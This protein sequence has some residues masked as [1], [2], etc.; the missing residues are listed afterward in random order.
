VVTLPRE[1]L[2]DNY[3]IDKTKLNTAGGIAAMA[4]LYMRTISHRDSQEF[5]KFVWPKLSSMTVH[6]A[7]TEILKSRSTRVEKMLRT[8]LQ[9]FS[10]GSTD[11]VDNTIKNTQKFTNAS[12]TSD[13][14]VN[15]LLYA[16]NISVADIAT[17]GAN[18]NLFLR[19]HVSELLSEIV[20][21]EK[22]RKRDRKRRSSAT[23]K[24]VINKK[25]ANYVEPYTELPSAEFDSKTSAA[26]NPYTPLLEITSIANTKQSLALKD[27]LV[28]D[29]AKTGR[30]FIMIENEIFVVFD[31][32]PEKQHIELLTVK[33]LGVYAGTDQHAKEVV[34]SIRRMCQG[35]RSDTRDVLGG[36]ERVAAGLSKLAGAR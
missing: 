8:T 28:A 12:K 30:L 7:I 3:T 25:H 31:N 10:T 20:I 33:A 16:L 4:A 9:L 36:A 32:I 11:I 2:S 23:P 24:L 27:K 21:E 34:E 1:P 5:Y 14:N 35:I 18:L 19:T 15:R 17:V 26:P 13:E 22:S 6:A 29:V